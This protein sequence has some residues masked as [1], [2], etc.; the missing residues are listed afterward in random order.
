MNK[1]NY[2]KYELVR[3]REVVYR[4]ITNNFDRRISEHQQDKKFDSARVVGRSCTEAGAKNW[5]ANSLETYRKNHAGNNPI[6]NKT[7]HG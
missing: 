6:Y 3:G 5:E 2:T 4:G 1:R 7:K